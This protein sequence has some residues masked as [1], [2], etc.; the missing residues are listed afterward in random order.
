MKTDTDN[1][2]LVDSIMQSAYA[3]AAAL[4]HGKDTIQ[5]ILQKYGADCIEELS[6]NQYDDVFSEIF[7][8]EADTK[9]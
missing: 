3:V 7:A 5:Q 1:R 4:P 6:P 9:D 8:V 2:N